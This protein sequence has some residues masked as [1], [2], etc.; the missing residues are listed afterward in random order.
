MSDE[1]LLEQRDAVLIVTINRPAVRNAINLATAHALADA[2]DRLDSQSDLAVGVLTGAGTT[3]CAGMDLKAFLAGER[4]SIEGRGFAGL[5]ERPPE[6]P[7]I[8]AV[9]GAAVA[10]GFEIVLSCDLIVAADNAYF[11]FPEVKRGLVAAGGGLLRL[12]GRIPY[13]VAME[14]S[15]T[16]SNV[17]AK[18]AKEVG[19]VNKVT[20]LDGALSGALEL[21]GIIGA[22]APLALRASKRIIATS[23]DWPLHEAFD[24]QREI[25]EPVRSSLDAREG[26]SA[27]TEKRAPM[28]RGQ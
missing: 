1:V 14:W 28:W 17:S 18:E 2:M 8:A 10:G 5:V 21:A 27:F 7:L 22:N 4:P 19:L 6:K 11:G 13:H 3:F 26:A 20:S 23:R 12:P 16:G 24:R 25:T 9:E 15:L